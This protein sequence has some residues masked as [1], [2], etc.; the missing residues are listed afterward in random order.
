MQLP[1]INADDIVNIT[2]VTQADVLPEATRS[3][4]AR[5]LTGSGNWK[6]NAT[7]TVTPGACTL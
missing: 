5:D 1:I 2:T 6:N 3:Y 7:P 4:D